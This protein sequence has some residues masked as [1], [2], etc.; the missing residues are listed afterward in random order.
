M[1][2]DAKKKSKKEKDVH[3][4]HGL[5]FFYLLNLIIPLK[6]LDVVKEGAIGAIAYPDP[7]YEAKE[8]TGQ[9]DTFPNTPWLPGD[10]VKTLSLVMTYHGY[11]DPTTPL[12]PSTCGMAHLDAEKTDKYIPLQ[13]ISYDDARYLLSR[14]KGENN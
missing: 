5:G 6:F 7:Y 14:M 10:A 3:F 4:I 8:G 2:A 13:P 11:G 9:N 1:S 12:L